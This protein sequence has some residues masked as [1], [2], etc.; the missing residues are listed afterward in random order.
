MTSDQWRTAAEPQAAWRRPIIRIAAM[1]ALSGLL[2]AGCSATDRAEQAM[3]RGDLTAAVHYYTQASL[4]NPSDSELAAR[5]AEA[6]DALMEQHIALARQA[7]REGR[8]ETALRHVWQVRRLAGEGHPIEEEVRLTLAEDLLERAGRALDGQLYE[9]ARDFAK[10]AGE[11]ASRLAEPAALEQR[12]DQAEAAALVRRAEADAKVGR[13]SEAIALA[14]AAG[15]LV[16]DDEEIAGLSHAYDQ[17]RRR[18]QFDQAARR[19]Q[20][21]LDTNSLGEAAQAMSRI[22]GLEIN[23]DRTVEL[24]R[25]YEERRARV[26]GLV[27]A[28]RTAWEQGDYTEALRRYDSAIAL[29]ADRTEL[30]DERRAAATQQRVAEAVQDGQNAMAAGD[31]DTAA[32]HFAQAREIYADESI[33]ALERNARASSALA[34]AAAAQARGDRLAAIEALMAALSEQPDDETAQRLNQLRDDVAQQA[35]GRADALAAEGKPEE[36]IDWLMGAMRATADPRLAERADELRV[37]AHL[38]AAAEAEAAQA[39]DA[40]REHYLEA[41]AIDGTLE[42]AAKRADL[43]QPLAEVSAR[44]ARLQEVVAERDQQLER[45]ADELRDVR[46]QVQ[47]EAIA[48]QEIDRQAQRLEDSLREAWAEN[49]QLKERIARL[50]HEI[51]R[52]ERQLDGR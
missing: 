15:K 13:Y 11:I 8:V 22:E 12:I 41:L 51:A 49:Q 20:A 18:A 19:L 43:V 6:S 17:A 29:A 5:L 33:I 25:Q 27:N 4:E 46:R 9:R 26:D 31:F 52:L 47:T 37:Q 36:A 23:P 38:R 16:P 14:D 42:G 7:A 45:R 32:A 2:L 24:R 35:L 1:A 3:E 10:Q 34:E 48:R 50:E 28:A 44:V 30:A 39:F 40:A 21:A